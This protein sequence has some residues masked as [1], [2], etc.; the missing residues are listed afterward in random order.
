MSPLLR[1]RH[2]A[3]TPLRKRR[4]RDP[5]KVG[6]L[7]LVLMS[8]AA[9][10]AFT[11]Q[12]P[13][14]HGYRVHAIFA[15]SNQL[16]KG[17]PVRIAGVD[18]GKVS[19]V[20]RGPGTTQ[21]VTM[22][23]SSDGQPIHRDA[24][25]KI[26]PRLFLEGG[27]FIQLDP[28]TPSAPDIH[29]GGT[30]P[31]PQTT[32]PVQF[33]QILTALDQDTRTALKSTLKVTA[34]SL[35]RGSVRSIRKLAPQ[36]APTLEDAAIVAQALRGTATHDLSGFIA[37][38]SQITG[39]LGQHDAQ[40]AGTVTNLNRT[41]GALA[42]TGGALAATVREVDAFLRA[43]PADLSAFDAALPPLAKVAAAV[44]PA[45]RVAPPILDKT[46]A[47]LTQ[48]AGLSSPGEL[49]GLVAKLAP[50]I[51]GF[52]IF[53]S[54][55]NTLFPLVKPATDCVVQHLL[56]ALSVT[57][58]DGALSSGRPAYQDLIHGLVGLASSS[59][60]FDGNG[61]WIRYLAAAGTQT[62][63][64]GSLSN[65]LGTIVGIGNQPIAGSRPVWFGPLGDSAYRPD[66]KCASQP[67]P[68]LRA[69]ASVA[70]STAA[71]ASYRVL[72]SARKPQPSTSSRNAF[73]RLLSQPR[74][75][76]SVLKGSGR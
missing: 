42:S 28:G 11:K 5:L 1:R 68:N 18:V 66:Q 74:R 44:L 10:W 71:V 6:I 69:R 31:L 19:A 41:A 51:H 63:S 47:F 7:I 65:A 43:A 40:L 57:V 73:R 33:H 8:A 39:T 56:P 54:R 32:T 20:G 17:S 3:S 55:L 4:A 13:F 76:L 35:D 34:D 50:T 53:E 15:S 52:P 61:P 48:L 59:Q 22:E 12:I 64:L 36:L 38:T 2:D 45:V 9:Y 16:K 37:A 72:G 23:I 27:F 70:Q 75:L 46:S 25:V 60:N 67:A 30:I 24:T 14:V 49:R 29:S 21:D 58:P 26:K 62:L